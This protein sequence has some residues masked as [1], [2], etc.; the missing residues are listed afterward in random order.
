MFLFIPVN[1]RLHW[2]LCVVLIQ[3]LLHNSLAMKT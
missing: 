2:S 3:D 1:Q